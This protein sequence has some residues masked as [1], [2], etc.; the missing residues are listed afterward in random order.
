MIQEQSSSLMTIAGHAEFD[1]K[2][3][4]MAGPPSSKKAYL[5]LPRA[6]IVGDFIWYHHHS[7]YHCSMVLDPLMAGCLF[8]G[9]RRQF[10]I[11]F[12]IFGYL[13]AVA[14]P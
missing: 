4:Y 12:S 5:A 14:P 13:M 1:I 6:F 7:R 3:L 8:G 2:K 9:A 11:K 10:R